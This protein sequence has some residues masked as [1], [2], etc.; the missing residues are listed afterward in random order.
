MRDLD[1]PVSVLAG[2]LLGQ[3]GDKN[4]LLRFYSRERLFS[5]EARP[6]G[7]PLTSLRSGERGVDGKELAHGSA[8]FRC[9][10]PP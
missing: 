6:I 5:D 8:L 10:L 1:V 7:C 4:Y 3:C 2:E 9:C